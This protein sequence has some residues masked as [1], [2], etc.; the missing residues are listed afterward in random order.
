MHE[1]SHSTGHKDR[2]NRDQTGTFGSKNYAFEELVAEI[3]SVFMAEYFITELPEKE[4]K[5]HAAYIQSWAD[6]IKSDENYLFRAISKAEEAADYMIDHGELEHLRTKNRDV[7]V[8]TE[9]E[10]EI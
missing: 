1:L 6:A 5:N 10:Y 2:L 7:I 3:S 8:S 4:I 9:E